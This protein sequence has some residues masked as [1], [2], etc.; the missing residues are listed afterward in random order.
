MTPELCAEHAA[1]FAYYGLQYGKECWFG[2]TL[3]KG[4]GQRDET[5]CQKPCAGDPEQTCGDGQRLNLYR[6]TDAHVPLDQP[7]VGDYHLQGCYTDSQHFRALT[8][9]IG[10][11]S[12]SPDLCAAFCEGSTYMG[13][14]YGKSHLPFLRMFADG[15]AVNVGAAKT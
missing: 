1:G 11:D 9:V 7:L 8:K 2:N 14:E 13:L 15:Q 5:E 10:D 6:R 12:M 4:S 3:R